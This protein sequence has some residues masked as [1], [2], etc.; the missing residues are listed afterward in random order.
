MVPSAEHM[1]VMWEL[2][3]TAGWS[4]R[5][6]MKASMRRCR[7]IG[8]AEVTELSKLLLL[9]QVEARAGESQ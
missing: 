8:S 6:R 1:R 5:L 9:Q 4:A 7:R 3:F 2:G